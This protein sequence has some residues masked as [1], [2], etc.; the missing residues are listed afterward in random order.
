MPN[1]SVR[2]LLTVVMDLLVV[3]AVVLV[4]RLIVMFFHQLAA[5]QFGKALVSLTNPLVIDF[6]IQAIKTP[7]KGVFDID[8]IA[9]IVALF[10]VEWILGLVRR[11]G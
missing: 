10:A 5:A 3:V 2:T 4:G 6:G 11:Q 9:M 7:Y 1:R 8:T